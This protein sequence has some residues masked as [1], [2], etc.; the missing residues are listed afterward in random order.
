MKTE[1]VTTKEENS[2]GRMLKS[3]V[4]LGGSSVINVGLGAIRTKILAVQL[5]PEL[6]GVM[7]L[8]S[9]LILMIQ[10]IA[11]LGLNQSAVREI[12]SAAGSNDATRIAT[13]ICA[14]R[15][16]VMATGILGIILT[17]CLAYPTSFLTFQ[18]GEH[19]WAIAVLSVVVFFGEIQAGQTALLQGLRRIKDLTALSIASALSSTLLSIP[20]VFFFEQN[21]VVPFL[22][23]VAV[24]QILASWWYARRVQVEPVAISW[25]ETWNA[26]RSMLSMGMTFV[27]SGVAVSA[28]AY[29]IRLAIN[30]HLGEAAVG[31]Y[32]AAFAIS[33]IYV[34]FVLQA[35]GT[36]FYPHLTSLG[37]DTVKQ[38]ELVN[39]QAKMAML[40]AIPGLVAALVLSDILIWLMYSTQFL[41]ASE[42]LRWQVLGLF[43]RIV[44]WPMGFIL[45]ARGDTWGRLF[46]ELS[47]A[48]LHVGLVWA[49][50]VW[51][52]LPGAGIAFA[53]LYVYYIILIYWMVCTRHGYELSR[54]TRNTIVAGTFA[55]GISFA[56][57][58]IPSY[59]WRVGAGLIFLFGS[60]F[61]CLEYL[62]SLIPSSR[63][64]KLWRRIRGNFLPGMRT[65]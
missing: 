12:A 10:G 8:Y 21:A 34:G 3:S 36:D 14:Y 63:P 55:I 50:V 2:Y 53:G 26:S 7:G 16:I 29:A 1:D 65:P 51:V 40:L 45:L 59:K 37:S 41:G 52:G 24:G 42:I 64:T 6:F 18:N 54:S 60:S 27:V 11:S 22:V 46:S 49:G 58:F 31:L 30:Q 15:R 35:M 9:T 39:D 28:S 32:Q 13:T 48:V 23:A 38:N 33:N 4:L 17:L 25:R 43:G 57:T 61:V 19:V 44:S 47:A 20:I 56:I 62:T 5:G